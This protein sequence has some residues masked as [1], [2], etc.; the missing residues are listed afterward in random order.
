MTCPEA[1]RSASLQVL[2]GPSLASTSGVTIQGSS[3]GPDGVFFPQTA[4]SLNISAGTIIGYVPAAS[5][6]LVSLC[7]ADAP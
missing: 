3:I 4:Y 6:G 5:A 1:V 7:S 2:T